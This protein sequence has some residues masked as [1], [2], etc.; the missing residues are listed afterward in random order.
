MPFVYHRTVR[1]QDTDAAGVVYFA[2]L[3]SMCHEAYEE[4]L[5]VAGIELQS[6]FQSQDLAVPIVHA[7]VDFMQPLHCGEALRIQLQ[8]HPTSATE[9]EVTYKIYRQSMQRP[10][11]RALTRHVC[12]QPQTR[13]RQPLSAALTAWLQCH[14]GTIL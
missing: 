9:F 3:L 6:F 4:S 13:S 1:F 11:S 14:W 10:A 8:A 5:R 2:N 7:E 12:I